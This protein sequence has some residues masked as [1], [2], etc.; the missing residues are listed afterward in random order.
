MPN[1]PL[2]VNLDPAQAEVALRMLQEI[3]HKLVQF[4]FNEPKEDQLRLRQHAYLRGQADLLMELLSPPPESPV[5][6]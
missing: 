4:N 5:A 2:R 1:Q 6:D 3:T